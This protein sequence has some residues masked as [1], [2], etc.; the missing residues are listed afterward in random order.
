M[1]QSVRRKLG[2][3]DLADMPD[4]GLRREIL[5]G[6]LFVTPSPSLA[7]QR[8]V[9]RLARQL[10]DYFEVRGLGE[11]FIAPLDVVLGPHDVAEPDLLVVTDPGLTTRRVVEGAPALVVEVLSPSTANRDRTIKARRYAEKR[12]AHYWMFDLEQKRVECLR[13]KDGE[14]ELAVVG[15]GDEVLS[16]FDWPGLTVDLTGLWR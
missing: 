4:D 12:I 8:V 1:V 2:Y 13:L 5:D 16:H 14:Y 15:E 10:D 3:D 9:K 11:V 7:H 6:E